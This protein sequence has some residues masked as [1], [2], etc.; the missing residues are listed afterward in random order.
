M[1]RGRGATKIDDLERI[2]GG[3]AAESRSVQRGARCRHELL[4]VR[5]DY[6][7]HQR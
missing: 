2:I 1:L 7:R 6:G 3:E 4:H 5:T